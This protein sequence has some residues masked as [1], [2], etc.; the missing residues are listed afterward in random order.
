M[1]NKTNPWKMTKPWK[2]KQSL[3]NRTK[4]WETS[5]NSETKIE[6]AKPLFLSGK[7]WFSTA[8]L[9]YR[10]NHTRL[11]YNNNKL[12]FLRCRGAIVS[13]E[14]PFIMESFDKENKA[15]SKKTKPWERRK[16]P[17]KALRKMAKPCEGWQ[18]VEKEEKALTKKTQPW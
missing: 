7:T 8:V 16:S 17:K 3:E 11:F 10:F 1:K 13:L 15:L 14:L 5:K 6:I 9:I 2:R 12:E 4:L 18:S